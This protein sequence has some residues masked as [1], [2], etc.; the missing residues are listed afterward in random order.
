MVMR[1]VICALLILCATIVF[2]QEQTKDQ[3]TCCTTWDD[4]FLYVSFKVDCPDVQAKHSAPNASV[5]GD[6][7]VEFYVDTKDSHSA[8]ITPSS[9]SMAVSASGGCE[10][11]VGNEAGQLAPVQAFTY[12]FGTNIQGTINNSDDIDM[13]YSVEIAVPWSLMKCSAPKVGDMM[14]FNVI[15]RRHGGKGFV[16]LSP[17]VKSEADI[18]DPSKWSSLVYAAHTFAAV[19]T[20]HEKIL[21]TKYVVRSP[22]IDGTISDKEWNRNT[23]FWLDMPMDG[24][25]YEAKFPTQ[26]LVMTPYYYW[27]QG[28]SRRGAMSRIVGDDG[29]YELTNFPAKNAGPWFSYDRVQWHKE[30]LSDIIGVGIG[31]VLPVYR[32]DKA[33]RAG[34]ADKGL[35][36]MVS[37][38]NE[39]R[40]EGKPYPRVAMLFDSAAMSAAYGSEKPDLKNEEV[41]RSFYGM[42]K[43][44]YDRVPVD[45]RAIAQAGKPNAGQTANVVFLNDSSCFVDLDSSFISYCNDHF[46]KDFG[47]TLV[48]VASEDYAAKVQGLDGICTYGAGLGAK[49]DNACRLSIGSVGPGFDNSAVAEAGKTLFRSRMDGQTYNNDWDEILQFNPNWIICDGWTS[50]QNGSELCSSRQFGNKYVDATAAKVEQFT[51]KR[52]NDAQYISWNVPSVIPTKSFAMAEFTI[53]NAGNSTWKAIDGYALSYRWYRGGRYYGESK[54]RR[55]LERDVAPGATVTIP[56]GIATVNAQ[57]TPIPEGDC[58]VRVEMIRLSDGK[59]FSALGDE[60]LMVPVKIGAPKDWDVEYLSCDTQKLMAP[61]QSYKTVVKVRNDGTQTWAH[62]VACLGC[63]L[64]KVSNYTHDNPTEVNEE[65]P[66]REIRSVLAKDCAPGEVAEFVV[67]LNLTSPDRKALPAWKSED[68]WSYQLRFDIYNGQQWLSELGARTLNRVADIFDSDYGPRLVDAEIPGA[69]AAGQEFD[70]KVVVRNTGTQVWDAKKT[71]IGYHWY[72]LDGSEITWDDAATPITASLQPGMPMVTPVKV[73][74][75]EFDGQYVLVMDVMMNDKWLSLEPLTRGGDILPK[76]VE[77]TGGK[78]AYVDLSAAYDVVASSFDTDRSVGNFSGSGESFPAELIPP[79]GVTGEIKHAYPAGYNW[80]RFEPGQN[81]ISFFYPDKEKGQKSAIACAGQSI[82]V[83]KGNYVAVHILGASTRGTQNADI[84]LAY[85]DGT[86]S[87]QM[88][89][90]DW[91]VVNVEGTEVGLVA[92]HRHSSEGDEIGKLCCLHT[93]KIALDPSKTLTAIVLPK[94]SDIKIVAITLER[95][96]TLVKPVESVV[97]VGKK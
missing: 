77:V 31:V 22:L 84:S 54:V 76:T 94:N 10:F 34:F 79:D 88:I 83:D 7:S 44:F 3:A 86:Q 49:F 37:A 97:A 35:D 39:L 24:I 17:N 4:T 50:L 51:G 85:A 53:R 55:P 8:K 68:V 67:D 80:K 9:F 93:C 40:D 87:A 13:G 28:D 14:G 71:R 89:A 43:D 64:Y 27:Y 91:G 75:P 74:A 45:F 36:C 63:K 90:G 6:D 12:K 21:S 2:A 42:I 47:C 70:A 96:D 78:L 69:V 62:G 81:R 20:N 38:L 11:R 32:G 72:S 1:A 52:D 33:S 61:G 60:P 92:R 48:W 95:Q 46:Q 26:H 18:S 65:V 25:V 16:S 56:I 15:I 41:Q 73:K 58:E 29:V 57:G 82:A 19:T 66:I 5:A 23:T 30:E 59:W